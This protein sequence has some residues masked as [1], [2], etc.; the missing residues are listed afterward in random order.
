MSEDWERMASNYRKT[1]GL[2]I[3]LAAVGRKETAMLQASDHAEMALVEL[4]RRV[5]NAALDEAAGVL[6][7]DPFVWT[8]E[9]RDGMSATFTKA[10][11]K[12]GHFETLFAVAS[13]ILRRRVAAI[14]AL[15]EPT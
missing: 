4:F 5:R 3:A 10:T 14:L 6:I 13:W 15:K 9:E 11:H 12:H 1:H 2:N 7:P 8:E